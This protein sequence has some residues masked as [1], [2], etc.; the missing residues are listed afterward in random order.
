MLL[1]LSLFR[2]YMY[3]RTTLRDFEI[4]FQAKAFM[5]T[6]M[7]KH[8]GMLLS[9]GESHLLQS[10]SDRI[11]I[12]VLYFLIFISAHISFMEGKWF[13]KHSG[14]FNIKSAIARWAKILGWKFSFCQIVP[15]LS[16]SRSNIRVFLKKFL[17][18]NLIFTVSNLIWRAANVAEFSVCPVH[19]S[20][21]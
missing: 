19:T 5:W 11:S 7:V 6:Q 2:M 18:Q 3:L 16:Y 4:A 21:C 10:V 20:F 1:H 15:H 14:F 12:I 9:C 8:F 13:I 17:E